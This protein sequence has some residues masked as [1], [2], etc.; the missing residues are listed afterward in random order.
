MTS[1]KRR[2]ARAYNETMLPRGI[3]KNAG[4]TDAKTEFITGIE[5]QARAEAQAAS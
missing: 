2:L 1:R 4:Y 3:D 5:E